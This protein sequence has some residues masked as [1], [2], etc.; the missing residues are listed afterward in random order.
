MVYLILHLTVHLRHLQMY[1]HSQLSWQRLTTHYS[2]KQVDSWM[3]H[4]PN[5]SSRQTTSQA[6]SAFHS[7]GVGKWVVIHVTTWIT[8][9]ETR[10]IKLQTRVVYGWLVVDQS[11]VAGLACRLQ[12]RLYVRCL[13]HEQRRC[14]CAMWLYTSVIYL[15]ILI[16]IG[17][18]KIWS[19]T[20][21]QTP[22]LI[23]VHLAYLYFVKHTDS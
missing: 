5:S 2:N 1:C 18:V 7:F 4:G 16:R 9:V 17:V 20:V 22:Y 11:V 12:H 8:G 19:I 6:N 14:S 13:W 10:L 15:C 3:H 23:D 21:I